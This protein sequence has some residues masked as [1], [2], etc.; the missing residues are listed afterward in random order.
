VVRDC[1]FLLPEFDDASKYSHLWGTRLIEQV[2]D[3]VNVILLEREDATRERFEKA[4]QEHPGADVCFEDHGSEDCLC[5]QG[6]EDCVLDL[7]NVGKAAG[8]VIYTMACLSAKKLGAV[9]HIN[10]GCVYV[11]Y[12]KEFAFVPDEEGLFCGAANSGFIAYAEGK[13]WAEVKKIMVEAFNEAMGRTDN[14]WTKTLLAWDRD[15]LRIY[16]PGVDSPEP[17][18]PLRKLAVALFGPK[19]GWKLSRTHALGW[20]LYLVGYGIALHDFAH[21]TYELKGTCLSPEGGYLGF[22]LIM[23][24]FVLLVSDHVRWLKSIYRPMGILSFG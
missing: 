20:M 1:I 15:I 24:G 18:C 19:I 6:G 4:L 16:A 23:L 2:K 22:A 5:A 21:E 12:I 10:Y 13:G 9:A 3:K 17:K 7:K 8:R 14:P 11:G